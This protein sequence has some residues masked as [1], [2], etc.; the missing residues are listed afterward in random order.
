MKIMILEFRNLANAL[1]VIAV[2][3]WLSLESR[4][5]GVAALF[6]QHSA[7]I[8]IMICQFSPPLSGAEPKKHPRRDFGDHKHF[9]IENSPES[10]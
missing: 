6:P 5:I 10:S 4:F 8:S 7:H 2:W 9:L 3:L 1:H